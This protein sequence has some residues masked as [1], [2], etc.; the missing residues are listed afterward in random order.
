MKIWRWLGYAAGALA[1]IAVVAAVIVYVLSERSLA[2]ASA[3]EHAHLA[4]PSGAQL[5]DGQRQL[6]ILGCANCHGEKLQGKL[7][8]DDP[9]LA[10]LYA[11][12][13]T[14]LAAKASDA[15]LERAIRQGIGSDGR[16]LVIMPAAEYQ[17]LTDSEVAA[18]IAAIR[19]TPRGGEAQPARSI[20]P[21]GRIGLVTGKFR[22]QPELVKQYLASPIADLGPQFEFGRHL[23]Q[24]NCSDCHGADLK[25]IELE[26]GVVSA[27]LQIAG[28]YDLKQFTTLLR[29]GVPPSRKNLK[30]MDDVARSDFK[31]LNDDE[32]AAMHAYLVELANRRQ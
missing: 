5:A 31:H 10:R 23:V 29:T 13:L 6:R 16:A 2:R 1:G 26:P 19:A 22:T 17:F 9:K 30:L 20:G 3:S 12:N 21:I 4:K 32:I 24:T 11:P 18:L 25:G 14:L 28:A 7:F 15:Q 8:L 27:D